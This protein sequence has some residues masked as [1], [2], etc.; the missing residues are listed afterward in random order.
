MTITQSP[1]APE[2]PDAPIF[3]PVVTGDALLYDLQYFLGHLSGLSGQEIAIR[4][5]WTLAIIAAAFA[6]LWLL[7]FLLRL[8]ARWLSPRHDKD[9]PAGKEARRNVGSWTMGAARFVIGMFALGTI[10]FVWGFDVRGGALGQGLGVIWRAGLIFL[11]ALAAVEIS[12]FAIT[13]VLHRGARHSRDLRRAAQLRT[14]APVLKAVA[15]TFVIFV[16]VMMTLSEFGVD[17]GPLIAGAGI[18]GLAVGFGAQTI[19]KD[20]LTGIFLILEDA[21]S[22]GD[23]IAIREFG[24]VVEDMN[25]RTIK[26]RDFDGTLHIFPFSE[27]QVISNRTKSFSYAVFELS[28]DYGANIGRALEV[29]KDTGESLANDPAFANVLLEDIEIVGVDQLADS[30]VILKARIKT[31]PGQ[32]WSVKREYLKR[33]KSNF[34]DAG[35]RIPFPHVKLV[36]PDAPIPTETPPPAT[37]AAE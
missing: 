10:L 2:T 33:I 15:H 20:F 30:A 14:L 31:A 26:L 8:A 18:V 22:I 13:R 25:I 24:G 16:A 17:I 12:G 37:N 11:F 19:V 4:A 32:Q 9:A 7:R 3:E 23:V 21:V 6:L 28:I 5:G 36:A 27:A 29:M 34:D 1:T 35:I